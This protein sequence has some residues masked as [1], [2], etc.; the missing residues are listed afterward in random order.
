MALQKLAD[1]YPNY[2]EEIFAGDDIKGFDV[3]AGDSDEKVGTVYDA[4]V[5]DTGR[6]RYLVIDTGIWIFGKKVLLPIGSARFDYGARR[7]HATGL[8]NKAQA[9][10]LPA[11]NELEA[12]DY[13]REEE[14]RGVYRNQGTAAATA[15]PAGYDRSSY[16][17]DMD[18]PLYDTN[19][20]QHQNLKLY[21]ER[22][23]A[24]K[25]RA[26][27]GEVAV[28]KRVETETARASVPIEKERVVIDRVT[29]VEAGRVVSVGEADFQS[30][31]VARME[32]YEETADIHKEAFVR[33]EV[34]VR[35]EVVRTTVEGEETLRR[36]EL[37]VKTDGTAV[38]D[39]KNI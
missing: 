29:P 6:F 5:D 19:E 2:Q 38:V 11:Y 8:R 35:K 26:K 33:E 15:T 23:I 25:H 21:E 1:F 18:R 12:I 31:E 14:V 39:N 34:N 10:Q 37:D 30:G 17:Y 24:N 3:Y 36:E 22:L 27:T 7:V 9:E 13:D 32:V 28:G 20:Q 4:L 16:S